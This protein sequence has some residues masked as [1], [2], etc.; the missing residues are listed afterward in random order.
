MSRGPTMPTRPNRAMPVILRVAA[1]A[2]AAGAVTAAGGAGP[3]VEVFQN[4]KAFSERSVSVAAGDAVTFV[5]DDKN[6]HNVY[7]STPGSEFDLGAQKPG[8]SDAHVFTTPGEVK[9]RCAIHPRM[10]LTVN[11]D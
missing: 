9:V 3:G 5:N 4:G 7:S 2:V 8:A 10:R 6:V 1:F 11:V